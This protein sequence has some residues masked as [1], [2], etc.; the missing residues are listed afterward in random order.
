MRPAAPN[1]PSRPPAL[2]LIAASLIALALLGLAAAAPAS[3]P[4]SISASA[5]PAEITLGATVTVSGRLASEPAQAGAQPLQLEGA[6]YPFHVFTVIAQTQSASDGSFSFAATAPQENTRMRVSLAGSPG[7]V[8][9]SLHVTVDPRVA[10]NARSLGPGRVRLSIRIALC[11]VSLKLV[12]IPI[13]VCCAS[14][15]PLLSVTVMTFPVL[16]SRAS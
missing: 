5:G 15:G 6:P 3:A 11:D 10:I 8:S 14:R 2:I 16:E 1:D 12:N 4:P 9:A 7:V 13:R